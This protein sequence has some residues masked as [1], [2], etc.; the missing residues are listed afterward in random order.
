[1]NDLQSLMSF[2]G[3][4]SVIN[5][6]F[7]VLASVMLMAMKDNLSALHGTMFGLPE[8]EI[9]LMY[10]KYLAYYKILIFVFAL[11]PYLALR[12]MLS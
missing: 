3:W 12:V 7:L 11:S 8:N 2:F 9:K 6:A 1:M 4:V 5:I 10:F